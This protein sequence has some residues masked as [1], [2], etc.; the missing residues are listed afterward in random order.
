ME[1]SLA[2]SLVS[3]DTIYNLPLD[4]KEIAL[5]KRDGEPSLLS[6]LHIAGATLPDLDRKAD[7]IANLFEGGTAVL[8]LPMTG[9]SNNTNLAKRFDGAGFKISYTTR[10]KTQLSVDHQWDMGEAIGLKWADVA[11]HWGNGPTDVIG[12]TSVN[13]QANFYYRIIP[14]IRGFGLNYES[15][16][17]CGGMSGLL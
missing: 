10:I 16:D 4:E 13:H 17:I 14:E 8:Q 5:A 9:L 15:V 12:F 7:I 1:D 2:N 3:Y 11:N 6:R